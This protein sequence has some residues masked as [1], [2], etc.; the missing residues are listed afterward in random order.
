MN[1]S[2]KIMKPLH[3]LALALG[4][5]TS[6][7]AWGQGA[8]ADANS[9]EAISVAGQQGGNIVVKITLKQPLAN[10]PAGFTINNP[11]R[12]AFDFPNTVNAMGKSTQDIKEGDLRS[13]R[14]GQGA[15]RTRVVFSLDKAAR[16]DAAVD[17]SN[18]VITLQPS[19]AAARARS[20]SI[21]PT[22]VRAS[23]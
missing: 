15:N 13:I 14:V 3:G 11:P 1:L 21:C 7:T 10:P 5:I 20:S 6:L 4:L 23:T 19:A 8:G 9:L 22:R 2:D 16:F 17:G 18:V 12:I